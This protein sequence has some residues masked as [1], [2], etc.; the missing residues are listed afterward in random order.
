MSGWTVA[1][2]TWLAL[3]VGGFVAIEVPAI[4]NKQ[5]GDTLSEHLRKWFS[6]H[7]KRGKWFWLAACT[8]L[9]GL[10]LWL[11]VHIAVPGSV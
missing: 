6:T 7:T 1:W 10:L 3:V 4:R 11:A 2:V 9:A 5:P 8:G